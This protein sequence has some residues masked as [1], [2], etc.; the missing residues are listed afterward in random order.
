LKVLFIT[1]KWPPAVGGMETYAF[2]LA[3]ELGKISQ[4]EVEALPGKITG[5][6]PSAAQLGMFFL[7]NLF[8]LPFRRTYDVYHVGDMV[9][10]PLAVIA[11]VFKPK[12]KTAIT[13]YGLDLLYGYREGLAP[14]IYRTYIKMAAKLLNEKTTIIAISRATAQLCIDA[15]FKNV[16]VV[17]LGTAHEAKEFVG[18]KAKPFVLFVGRLVKRKGAGWFAT[19]V[20]PLLPEH[21][22]MKVAGPKWDADE[23]AALNANARV[24]YLGLVSSEDLTKLRQSAIAVLMPNISMGVRDFEGFGLTAPEAA[25]EGGVL[26]AAAVEGVTDAVIDG[27]TGFLMPAE[28][29]EAWVA[30][31]LEIE[32]WS[33]TKRKTFIEAAQKSVKLNY[34]WAKVA[35]NTLKSYGN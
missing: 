23:E 17:A 6:P 26:I 3:R 22:E 34:S 11:R 4:L 21:I 1:R 10:W 30:K 32:K 25:A 35:D 9:L 19:N 8:A 18:G 33:A 7:R 15:G 16:E 28:S 31:I 2:E 5:A 24:D 13:A 29:P 27:E 14:K 12:S 20:M